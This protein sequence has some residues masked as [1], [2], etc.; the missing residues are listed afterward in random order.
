MRTTQDYDVGRVREYPD[1]PVTGVGWVIFAAILLGL[2]GAWNFF[3]GIA[4]FLDLLAGV[5]GD[6]THHGRSEKRPSSSH[7]HLG[8]SLS[9]DDSAASTL[10]SGAGRRIP[11][12]G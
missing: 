12:L 9:T 4:A 10:A 6:T 2:S 7:Q 11:R 1:A 3:D 5:V 8:T